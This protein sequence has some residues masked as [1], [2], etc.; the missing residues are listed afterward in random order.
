MAD[1][2]RVLEDAAFRLSIIDKVQN[3]FIRA[4]LQTYD[5]YSPRE[6]RE[7]SASTTV[8]LKGLLSSPAMY[9]MFTADGCY[10]MEEGQR[11]KDIVLVNTAGADDEIM[12]ACSF[13]INDYMYS[14]QT[15]HQEGLLNEKRPALIIGDEFQLYASIQTAQLLDRWR[16]IGLHAILAHHDSFQ[17]DYRDKSGYLKNTREIQM[18]T[19][20]IFGGITARPELE[21]V[22]W[23]LFM[24]K[25]DPN[26]MADVETPFTFMKEE[27]RLQF[28]A[29]LS[30]AKANGMSYP[31]TWG[32][33]KGGALSLVKTL[34]NTGLRSPHRPVSANLKI[35][36]KSTLIHNFSVG[37]ALLTGT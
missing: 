29:Q 35:I 34:G 2:I 12:L 26:R 3:P 22:T 24:D 4:Q 6:Q 37:Y 1:A 13:L 7:V 20:A 18:G 25:I 5:R 16:G 30:R 15:L 14:A 21:S 27:T 32:N 8:R 9:T 36:G 17:L 33:T 31:E 28:S 10:D 11:Q 23:R 19:E